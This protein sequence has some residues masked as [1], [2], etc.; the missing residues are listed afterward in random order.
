MVEERLARQIE[1]VVEIDRLKTVSSLLSLTSAR[2]SACPA[3]PRIQAGS[4][5]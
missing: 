1:F 2:I 4:G 3:I 5:S